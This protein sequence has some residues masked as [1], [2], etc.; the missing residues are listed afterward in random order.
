L[1]RILFYFGH[2]SQFLF[3][4][5]TIK[6]LFSSGNKVYVLIKEKDVLEDLVKAEGLHYEYLQDAKRSNSK[7]GLFLSLIKRDW[8]LLKFMKNNPVDVLVGTD[9]SLAHA[10]RIFGKDVITVL[11]D[12]YDIIK[13]LAK[14]TYPFTNHILVPEVCDV[15]KYTEKKIGY[16]GYM[17]LAYLTTGRFLPDRS[18][19]KL[20]ME[21]YFLLRLS[22]LQAHHD[23]GVKG[24]N[25]SLLRN[26]IQILE[27]KGRVYISSEKNL[28]DDFEPYRLDL[29]PS[30]IHHY[31]YY[32]ELFISD[33]QSMSVE[34][35]L[36]GV[37]S[38][39]YS[40]FAGKISVLNELEENYQLTFGIKP[41]NT[42][43]LFEKIEALLAMDDRRNI[44][45]R[46]RR[47]MLG[48]KIDVSA[49][50]TWFLQDYPESVDVLKDNPEFYDQFKFTD[51]Q[52]NSMDY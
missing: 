3:A 5:D 47:K 40:D 33:S 41:G 37:P 20:K 31:L 50:L 19:V 48:E 21:P 52:L 2:P 23:V 49:F 13:H 17:K 1:K 24:L 38:I 9:A 8:H 11:E 51:E 46:R 29:N 14:V 7:T 27:K 4:K 35:A 6:T 42:N 39:R 18:R 26:I 34:A 16:P 36:L 15:G 45:Q 44:F 28:K 10:G 22:A 43:A 32:S 25:D 30:D 12:D